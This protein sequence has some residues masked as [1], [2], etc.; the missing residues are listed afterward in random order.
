MIDGG[1]AGSEELTL[2]ARRAGRVA[3]LRA[4]SASRAGSRTAPRSRL[5]GAV[6]A[7]RAEP[8]PARRD[9]GR[10]G[11]VAARASAG[12]ARPELGD[13]PSRSRRGPGCFPLDAAEATPTRAAQAGAQAGRAS[14]REARRGRSPRASPP[15]SPS[16]AAKP[17]IPDPERPT[18]APVERRSRWMGHSKAIAL[19]LALALAGSGCAGTRW[20]L[21]KSL[22]SPGERS[23]GAS[24]GGLAGVRL[25]LPEAPVLHHR[26]QRAGAA[27]RCARA[28]SSTTASST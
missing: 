4:A 11:A 18:S 3:P 25:R 16:R 27:A 22:R 21:Q 24:R 20:W 6:P 17:E 13:C 23:R 10:R 5:G 26:A 14:A 1:D 7:V 9:R 12:R 8:A 2:R 28:A 19:A 15:R